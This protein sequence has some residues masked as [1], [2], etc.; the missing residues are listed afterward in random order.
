MV[1]R[2]VSIIE[3]LF[4]IGVVAVGLLGVIAVVPV[5]M[6]QAGKANT[7]D[8]ATCVGLNAAQEFELRGYTNPARWLG[9]TLSVGQSYAIDPHFL[10][11]NPAGNQFPYTTLAG[12]FSMPRLT[13]NGGLGPM[14][15][16]QADSLFV[17]HD[18]L[19]FDLPAEKTLPPVQNYPGGSQREYEGTISWMATV[20]PKLDQTGQFRDLYILSII[21][22]HRRDMQLGNERVAVIPYNLFHGAGIS[23]GDVTIVQHPA[24][25][26][27][28][29]DDLEVKAGHWVMLSRQMPPVRPASAPTALFRWYRVVSAD[30]ELDETGKQR[31][32]TLEGPDWPVPN[33]SDPPTQVV[34]VSNV[35]AVY[36]RTIRLETTSLWNY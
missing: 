1:R 18:D 11:R 12:V 24:S 14:T 25:T 22:F 35:V 31:D 33:S 5:G 19:V 16:A 30:P 28:P 27:T 29:A 4:A 2:G 36:E 13:L 7:T 9:S 20:V 21:V 23:G 17:G 34:I 15:A 6:N 26:N 10:T 32:V 3:V 8:R